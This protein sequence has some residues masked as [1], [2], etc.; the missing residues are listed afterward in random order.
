MS[1]E[2][3]EDCDDELKSILGE[4]KLDLNVIAKRTGEQKKS[5]IRKAEARAEDAEHV[6]SG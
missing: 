5:T 6:V 1:S 3:F 4:L 2:R